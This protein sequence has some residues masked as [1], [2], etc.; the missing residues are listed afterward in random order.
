ML[1]LDVLPLDKFDPLR[2]TLTKMN[3]KK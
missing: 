3:L 2:D 1:V